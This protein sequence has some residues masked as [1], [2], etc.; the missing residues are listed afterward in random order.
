VRWSSGRIAVSGDV[1]LCRRAEPAANIGPAAAA[2][3]IDVLAACATK[4]EATP[5]RGHGVFFGALDDP[6]GLTLPERTV[7]RLP[8]GRALP[9]EGDFRDWDDTDAWAGELSGRQPTEPE[10]DGH[11]PT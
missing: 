5:A 11:V 9:P 7:R 10:P 3:V 4:N 2:A 1:G 6:D 8:A